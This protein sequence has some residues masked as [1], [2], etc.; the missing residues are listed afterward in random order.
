[1]LFSGMQVVVLAGIVKSWCDPPGG[2][3]EQWLVLTCL[4]AAGT[5]LGL[6]ISAAAP[7]EEMAITLIPVA[8]LPQ[9]ILSGVIA[10]LEGLS[11]LLAANA[12]HGVLGQSRSG[13]FADRG[14][15]E[16]PSCG[17]RHARRRRDVLVH[18]G[19]VDLAAFVILS[20]TA[21]APAPDSLMGAGPAAARIRFR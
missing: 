10:P 6:A 7:T 21:D 20:C 16:R 5:A 3:A 1:M 15:G 11:K 12:H 2:F 9:I 4:A 14:S 13:R 17:T 8:I 19:P 18:A